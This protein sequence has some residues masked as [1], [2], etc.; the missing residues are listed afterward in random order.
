MTKEETK[1]ELK[2]QIAEKRKALM[3][4]KF[5]MPMNEVKD[6][7]KIKKAKKEIARLLTK[8]NANKGENSDGAK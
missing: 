4:I 1:E 2:E 3:D 8:I 5:Q 6:Y 7:S